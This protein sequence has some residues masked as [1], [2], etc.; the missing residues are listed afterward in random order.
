MACPPPSRGAE[1]TQPTRPNVDG[2][3][4]FPPAPPRAR[5]GGTRLCGG[6]LGA[7]RPPCRAGAA[8]GRRI[9]RAR[10]RGDS[11]GSRPTSLFLLARVVRGEG[12]VR[13]EGFTGLIRSST[14]LHRAALQ[15]RTILLV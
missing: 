3:H 8:E 9:R 15:R 11:A 6:A 2:S 10:Y 7:R 13:G 4:A 12:G 14:P 5:D 1:W